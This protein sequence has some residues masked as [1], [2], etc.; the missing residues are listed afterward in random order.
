MTQAS[1][2]VSGF[3]DEATFTITYLVADPATRRAAIIDPVLDFDPKSA[4]TAT[5]AADRVLEAAAAAGLEI[6]W[7]LE[8]HVHAD[9][10]TAAPHVAGR[11]G[12]PVAIGAGIATVQRTFKPIFG[13]DDLAVDG[14]QFARTFAD[15]ERFRIGSIEAEVMHTPGHTPSCVTYAIGDALFVG[16]TLFMP[17]FGTAR[18]DFPGGDAGT[19]FRSIRRVLARPPASRIFVGHDYK[20]P[21]RDAYAWE[22]TVADERQRNIHVH[23]GVEAADFVRM[24]NERDAKLALP[25]LILPAIQVNIRAGAMPPPE[26]DGQVYLRLPVDRL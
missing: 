13:A 9:H 22:S 7:V 26:A 12:A 16:D 25:T 2:T 18:C 4:R 8:T 17:D 11:T 24:R 19:L 10:L 1:P 15:G 5:R 23:D 6:E 20:A 21:G 14:S 3:F